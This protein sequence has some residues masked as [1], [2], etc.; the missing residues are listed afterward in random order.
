VGADLSQS[1]GGGET[2]AAAGAGDQGTAAVEAL[3]REARKG[4]G[5]VLVR[6]AGQRREVAASLRC[7]Q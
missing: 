2:D 1:S 5:A 7:S 4:H 6:V 3:G